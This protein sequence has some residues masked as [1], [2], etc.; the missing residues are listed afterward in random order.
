MSFPKKNLLG[1]V[2]LFSRSFKAFSANGFILAVYFF[3]LKIYLVFS[4]RFDVGMADF[5]SGLRTPAANIA[6]SRHNR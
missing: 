5:I 1:Q 3:S 4:K 2:F 6:Y